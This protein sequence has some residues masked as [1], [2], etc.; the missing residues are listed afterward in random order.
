MKMSETPMKTSEP[1]LD[2]ETTAANLLCEKYVKYPS[3]HWKG[4]AVATVP[5]D[6]ADAVSYAMG[7][8]GS[9]VVH[10]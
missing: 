5:A 7:F 6:M 8:F 4:P 10:L 9:L 2:P 1:E 3:G